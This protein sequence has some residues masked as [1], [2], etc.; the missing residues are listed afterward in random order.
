MLS[1]AGPDDAIAAFEDGTI[2]AIHFDHL[3][4]VHMAW[5]YARRF[6]ALQGTTL[7]AAALQRLTAKLGQA[8]KYHETIT[9]FLML[10]IAERCALDACGDWARFKT[11]NADIVKDFRR[12]L[13]LCYS[14]ERLNSTLARRQ[15]L[16]P[17]RT[18]GADCGS[19]SAATIW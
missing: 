17:D 15:F 14:P 8:R 4:H 5:C 12:L 18:P 9:G 6:G 7:F 3:A 1:F 13:D 16:L 10:L 11:R 19:H 2:D